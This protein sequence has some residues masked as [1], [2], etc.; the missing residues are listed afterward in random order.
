M[1]LKRSLTV[2][3]MVMALLIFATPFGCMA[4]DTPAPGPQA[5]LP[6]ST[7]EFAPVVEG[8]AVAHEFI[9]H[10]RGGATLK[11]LKVTAG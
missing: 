7:Y 3:V 10:N 1:V 2:M 6:A 11:I 5:F 8:T 4:T 9:L